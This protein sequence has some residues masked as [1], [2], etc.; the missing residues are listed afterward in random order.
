MARVLLISLSQETPSH[1]PSFLRSAAPPSRCFLAPPQLLGNR[2]WDPLRLPHTQLPF[3]ATVPTSWMLLWQPHSP[4]C[5]HFVNF[6]VF[7]PCEPPP[8]PLNSQ[9]HLP[10]VLEDSHR[11]PHALPLLPPPGSEMLEQP[12]HL[13]VPLSSVWPQDPYCLW[14]PTCP[15]PLTSG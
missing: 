5:L 1:H 14:L 11:Q 13:P 2:S 12:Q 6:L 15:R 3:Q 8:P 4:V 10:R 9:Q 7:L